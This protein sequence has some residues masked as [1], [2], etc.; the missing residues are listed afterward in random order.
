MAQR[1]ASFSRNAPVL[2]LVYSIES[3]VLEGSKAR[4]G[5]K[6]SEGFDGAPPSPIPPW[7]GQA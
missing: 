2:A 6:N 1:Y 5:Y 4:F 3:N 7:F